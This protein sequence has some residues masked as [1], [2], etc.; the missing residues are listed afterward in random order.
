LNVGFGS[1]VTAR[2]IEMLP[3]AGISVGGGGQRHKADRS[4][5][6]RLFEDS[7]CAAVHIFLLPS[8]LTM[9]LAT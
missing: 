7:D 6:S 8:L 9:K 1:K 3:L 5:G 2:A 4:G